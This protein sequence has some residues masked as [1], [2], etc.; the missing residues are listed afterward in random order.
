MKLSEVMEWYFYGK[1][2]EA[3][4]FKRPFPVQESN[5]DAK[6]LLQKSAKAGDERSLSLVSALTT[7]YYV[8]KVLRS[9]IPGYNSL[10]KEADNFTFSVKIKLLKA[11]KLVP[12]HIIR[13]AEIIRQTRNAFAHDI[14]ID[15]LEDLDDKKII[16]KMKDMYIERKIKT[17][18][19]VD[20]LRGVFFAIS[21]IAS[22]VLDSYCKNV[23]MLNAV[24]RTADT[25][26]DLEKLSEEKAKKFIDELRELALTEEEDENQ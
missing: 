14:N 11:L 23:E 1:G 7:E 2:E 17:D 19:G 9:F 5:T 3:A 8:D 20:D 12:S 21:Y 13:A 25:L 10:C 6:G 24:I 15:S 4:L 22:T 18:G 26:K 16:S